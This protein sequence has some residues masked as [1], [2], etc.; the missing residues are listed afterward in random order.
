MILPIS[1]PHPLP[2][3]GRAIHPPLKRRGLSGSF[4]VNQVPVIFAQWASQGRSPIAIFYV[5]R[6]SMDITIAYFHPLFH[7]DIVKKDFEQIRAT[8]ASNIVFAIHE[9]EDQRWPRDLERGLRQAQE[10]GLKVFLSLGCYGNLF[11]GPS[12]MPSWYTFRHPQTRVK[13]RHGRYHSITC[14]NHEVFRSWLFQEIEYLLCNYPINGILLDEPRSPDVTCFCSVCR[15]LCPD[16][17]DLQ[18]FQRRSMIDFLGALCAC[19][20]R[21][22]DHAKT[23]IVLLPQDLILLDELAMMPHLDIIGC[24]L[25]WQLLHDDIAK[26]E[27]WGQ[28]V[29]QAVRPQQKRS[30]LWFQNFNL[31]EQEE[32]F[33]EPAFTKILSAEPDEVACYYYWRNNEDP[34]WVWQTTRS[35]LRRIPRRQLYW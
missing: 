10:T 21:V 24:H 27:T 9:Q 22:N 15:A 31:S 26:L 25:F 19:I 13:D 8:G 14:Y 29:V 3:I 33:L 6:A 32:Q 5:E 12:H 7:S 1:H 2:R 17:A 20:K 11:A 23:A 16:I 28:R 4:P 34:E 30:Q 18:H 35:L